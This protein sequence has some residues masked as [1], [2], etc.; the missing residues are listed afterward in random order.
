M[1]F[2]VK[3]FGKLVRT[4]CGNPH[5]GGSGQKDTRLKQLMMTWAE[6]QKFIHFH[7]KPTDLFADREAIFG[8]MALGPLA[9]P[10]SPAS[11]IF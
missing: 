5:R 11:L 8:Y 1:T 9:V 2:I 6:K 7:F 3:Q 10:K 4:P